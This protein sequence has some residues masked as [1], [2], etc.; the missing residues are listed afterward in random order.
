MKTLWFLFI[1]LCCIS[2]CHAQSGWKVPK[3][4]EL[5]QADA[6]KTGAAHL[7]AEDIAL[8]KRVTRDV[9]EECAADPGPGDPGTALGLFGQLRVRRV[10]LGPH[11]NAGL[12]VQGTGVCMCG[13]V[14]NCPFWVIGEAPR[15]GVLLE[16]VGI[17]TFALQENLTARRFDL[18]VGSHDSAMQT[19]LQR[20]R[21]NGTK[22]Q[23]NGCALIDW[24][25]ENLNLL[26]RPRITAR[27]CP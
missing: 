24:D 23:L 22:Y 15:P 9:I 5:S 20:F 6:I 3:L 4:R 25:D 21:F 11:S 13:A 1:G 10:N 12:V 17:Q 19:D 16:T 8:L 7:S 2:D 18:L 26:R 14:G 27:E